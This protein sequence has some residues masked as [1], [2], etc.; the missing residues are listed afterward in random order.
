M[1]IP[2]PRVVL[3]S[4]RIISFPR[5]PGDRLAESPVAQSTAEAAAAVSTAEAVSTGVDHSPVPMAGAAALMAAVGTDVVE[6]TL[7]FNGSLQTAIA[8]WLKTRCF[9]T[10]S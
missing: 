1:F 6:R 9:L 5:F 7:N 10:A 8:E 3:A 4:G 2:R